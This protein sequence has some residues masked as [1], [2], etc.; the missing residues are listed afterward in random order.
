MT[1]QIS[2]SVCE[3]AEDVSAFVRPEIGIGRKEGR[4]DRDFI[5]L[6]IASSGRELRTSTLQALV[7][8]EPQKGMTEDA[9]E[10]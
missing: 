4:K 7:Y 1:V 8:T 10:G 3:K 2:A 9:I 5:D 6:S